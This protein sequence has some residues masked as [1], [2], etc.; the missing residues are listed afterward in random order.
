[1]GTQR[2]SCT[3]GFGSSQ[4]QSS[5]FPVSHPFDGN[6]NGQWPQQATGERA[7]PDPRT[8]QPDQLELTARFDRS[9][10]QAPHVPDPSRDSSYPVYEPAQRNASAAPFAWGPP[11]SQ[12]SS[13]SMAW[14]IRVARPMNDF[15]RSRSATRPT[16]HNPFLHEQYSIDEEDG[17]V[18]LIRCKQLDDSPV[19]SDAVDTSTVLE[20]RQALFSLLQSN[21]E[22]PN[23]VVQVVVNTLPPQQMA[24]QPSALP[25]VAAPRLTKKRCAVCLYFHCNQMYACVGSGD[26]E[27]C[28]CAEHSD[29]TKVPKYKIT[30]PAWQYRCPPGARCS[31][32]Y[33]PSYSRRSP[34]AWRARPSAATTGI[35]GHRST[36]LALNGE[37]TL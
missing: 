6:P 31:S 15:H 27:R 8:D 17:T 35:T 12:P 14:P 24:A 13:Q 34:P 9:Q 28:I 32:Y 33:I 7:L 3:A 21:V 26:R 4:W 16:I 36:S 20:S 1:M 10:S 18:F 11:L 5:A 23:E 19:G 37:R 29:H 25:A 30:K 22:T 2:G